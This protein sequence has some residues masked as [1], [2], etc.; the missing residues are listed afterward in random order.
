MTIIFNSCSTEV[1]QFLITKNSVGLLTDSTQV[2]DLKLVFP[3]DSLNKF[4]QF[5]IASVTKTFVAASV[6]RLWEEKKILF[7][8]ICERR[9][10]K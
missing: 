7:T 3:N 5:R 10:K 4:G 9:S 2:K 6:L 1:D 8:F